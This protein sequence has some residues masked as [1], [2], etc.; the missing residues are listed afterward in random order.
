MHE[1]IKSFVNNGDAI[2]LRQ[3]KLRCKFAQQ[4]AEERQVIAETL[5]NCFGEFLVVSVSCSVAVLQHRQP[6]LFVVN[7]GILESKLQAGFWRLTIQAFLARLFLYRFP[8][9]LKTEFKA[10]DGCVPRDVVFGR[11]QYFVQPRNCI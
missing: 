11:F 5:V 4:G 7:P 6:T 2:D 8:S 1:K 10:L 9:Q 3:I